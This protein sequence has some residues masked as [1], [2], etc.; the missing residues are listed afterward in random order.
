MRTHGIAMTQHVE[1]IEFKLAEGVGLRTT[2]VWR[3]DRY[4]H[5]VTLIDP[6]GE[7]TLLESTEEAHRSSASRVGSSSRK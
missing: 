2:F 1:S 3:D 6:K 4:A 5:I 7:Q